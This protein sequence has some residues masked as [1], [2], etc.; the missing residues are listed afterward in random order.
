MAWLDWAI[1]NCRDPCKALNCQQLSICSS[2]CL[3]MLDDF[4]FFT[5]LAY[6]HI[7]LRCQGNTG[8]PMKIIADIPDIESITE[9]IKTGPY[10]R[11]VY[12]CDN[13]VV[14]NQV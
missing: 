14:D 2:I 1:L 5:A 10:G 8:W 6:L 4:P 11:C 3:I 12:S 7:L 9:A 13:D